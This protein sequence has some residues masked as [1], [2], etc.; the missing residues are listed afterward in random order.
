VI[1]RN[2][3]TGVINVQHREPHFHTGGEMEL[4]TTI[5]EQV[6]CLVALASADPAAA[7]RVNVL[8]LV[9]PP[10]RSDR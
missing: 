5:G 9:M 2:R 8:D 7:A 4:L 3:V 1:A 6:G 10:V